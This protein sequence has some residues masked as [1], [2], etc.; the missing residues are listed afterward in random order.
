MRFSFHLFIAILFLSGSCDSSSTASG[1][2]TGAD[3]NASAQTADSGDRFTDPLT[4]T[5][6]PMI[7]AE[8]QGRDHSVLGYY[9]N[10]PGMYL[11]SYDGGLLLG[12]QND[13]HENRIDLISKTQGSDYIKL[14]S[15]RR[16]K[17]WEGWVDL[18]LFHDA[19]GDTL[20]SVFYYS[21]GPG[22][23]VETTFLKYSCGAWKEVTDSVFQIPS[24]EELAKRYSKATGKPNEGTPD[25]L[26][27][28]H[29][30]KNKI[31][32][33]CD[34]Q[35]EDGKRIELCTL[36]FRRGLFVLK[37]QE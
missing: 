25:I 10:V 28:P 18:A 26:L 31:V 1:N 4:D 7:N 37:K 24:R 19:G 16:I 32:V 13:S 22:C 9:L 30:D 14:E 15:N 36:E 35:F 2:N 12:G 33:I 5:V 20:F 6:V 21:C 27:E 8:W 17:T 3:T 23:N 11:V 34:P 29:P